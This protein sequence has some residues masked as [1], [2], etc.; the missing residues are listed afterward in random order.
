MV[1]LTLRLTDWAP[2]YCYALGLQATVLLPCDCIRLG[3]ACMLPAPIKKRWGRPS[4][5][6][7]HSQMHQNI[8][9]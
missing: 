2:D 9:T 3:V 4:S 1:Y 5:G 7:E 6:K 8:C